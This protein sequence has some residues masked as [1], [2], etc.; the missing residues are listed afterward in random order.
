MN[1][2]E[3]NRSIESLTMAETDPIV[4]LKKR[5][6]ELGNACTKLKPSGSFDQRYW[7]Q[8]A[9][10][11]EISLEREEIK[12]KVSRESYVGTTAQWEY[13]ED[14]KSILE[15][16]EAHKKAKQICE[17]RVQQL[18]EETPHRS[19]TTSFMKL[20]T[21]SKMGMNVAPTTGPPGQGK[22]DPEDQARFRASLITTYNSRYQEGRDYP[23][24]GNSDWL[25]CP[26]LHAWQDSRN[27]VAAHLF[28]YMHGQ[29]TMDAIFGKAQ[30]GP[31]LF[32]P[33]NGLLISAAIEE[34][35]DC[36]KFAIVPDLSDGAKLPELLRWMYHRGPRE[37]KIKILDR[38][39]DKLDQTISVGTN[40]KFRDLENRRLQFRSNARPAGRYLYFNYCIQVL[41]SAW[42][43][44]GKA[45]TKG[46]ASKILRE[47]NGK[48]F[49]GT[50]GRYI[51]QNM[52]RA[53]V[54]EL[55]H[56]YEA[57]LE[58]ASR[59]TGDEQ[60]LLDTAT[61]QVKRD[62][63]SLVLDPSEDENEESY[64]PDENE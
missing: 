42:Q 5:K 50:P 62:R 55:G 22:R 24:I 26:V 20:F 63:G 57:L 25:W 2:S 54:E 60:L 9:K 48:P 46:E 32:S 33:R 1:P 51:P 6:T 19:L 47:E 12:R 52:L 34:F 15:K 23:E 64:S 53:F 31:E 30:K 36:G 4:V 56:E 37:Y 16:I 58:G 8:A 49:W 21:T 29:S 13:T 7:A 10:T 18:D 45:K 40:L 28:A 61:N 11:E 3:L 39:W 17:R 35:F 41:R 44:A 27:M 43:R 14:A 38:T 59:T